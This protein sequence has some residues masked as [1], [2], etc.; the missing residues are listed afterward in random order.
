MQ[1]AKEYSEEKVGQVRIVNDGADAPIDD[2]VTTG[3][4]AMERDPDDNRRIV[5]IYVDGE[6]VFSGRDPDGNGVFRRIRV[7]D[8]MYVPNYN[9]PAIRV[10]EKGD[11][12]NCF[13]LKVQGH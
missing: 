1:T 7:G 9:Q 4:V 3:C 13:K 6:K 2:V 12:K 8:F 11:K 10:G 5:R